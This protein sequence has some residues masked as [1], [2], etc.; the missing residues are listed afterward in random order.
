MCHKVRIKK[1]RRFFLC[2]RAR[3]SVPPASGFFLLAEVVS[4]VISVFRPRDVAT[5]AAADTV[6]CILC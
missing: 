2:F 6:L 4:F 5:V 3:H 1:K